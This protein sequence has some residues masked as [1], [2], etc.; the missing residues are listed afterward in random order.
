MSE[1]V[2]VGSINADQ[3]VV[4]DRRPKKGET[5]KGIKYSLIPGGKGANQAVAAARLKKNVTIIGCVGNDY[6]GDFLLNEL[7]KNNVSTQYVTKSENTSTGIAQITV[8]DEDNSI[9]IVAGANNQMNIE[10]VNLYL[11]IILKAKIVILQL[12]IPIKTVEYIVERCFE[13]NIITILNPAPA[14]RLNKNLISKVTYLTPN[15]HECTIV[16]NE[17]DVQKILKENPNK[18]VL[19]RGE[20]GVQFFDGSN[21]I[22]VPAYKN[23]VVDT[24]GAGDTF[25]GALAAAILEG[26]KLEEAINFANKAASLSITKLGA[27]SGMPTLEELDIF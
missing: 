21:I 1:I 7:N 27:Q 14:M 6:L 15:E 23:K 13:N 18:V 11:D 16:F 20:K 2:V 5:I 22:S 17:H 25:N 10:K 4:A 12:E 19:T 24:T 9:I 8:A 26:K 3:V